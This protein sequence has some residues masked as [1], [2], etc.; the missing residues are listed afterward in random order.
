MLI[1]PQI[2]IGEQDGGT[3]PLAGLTEVIGEQQ[4]AVVLTSPA[5]A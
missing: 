4:N 5:F 3:R 2:T 1:E